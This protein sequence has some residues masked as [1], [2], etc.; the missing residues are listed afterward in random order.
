MDAEIG[1]DLPGREEVEIDWPGDD[2]TEATQA[3]FDAFTAIS[4]DLDTQSVLHRIV[5]T[6]CAL[7]AAPRG[8]LGVLGYDGQVIERIEHEAS[9]G[10]EGGPDVAAAMPAA[11]PDRPT[12]ALEVPVRVRGTPFGSLILSGRRDSTPFTKR[13]ELLVQALSTVAGFVIENARAYGL[14]ERRRR[15]L[16][17][18]GELTDLLMPPITLTEALERI[19]AAVRTASGAESSSVVQVPE[20]GTPFSA[21]SSGQVPALDAAEQ[22]TFDRAVRTVVDTGE[23]SSMT[24]SDDLVVVFAPL[25]AHLTIPG[26]LV[27]VR[28]R[29]NHSDEFEERELLLSFADQAALALDRTQALEDREA[30][31]VIS[32]RDRIARDL[33]DV[34]IQRL[35][36]AGLHM[37]SIKAAATPEL[38]ERIDQSVRDLDQTIRDIRGTIFEL[39]TRPQ[40]SLRS[41]IR[42]LVREY[43]PILGFAPSVQLDGPV[44]TSVD[45]RV[46]QQ[47]A[48]VL[49]ESLSNVARHAQAG[50]ASVEVRVTD[51]HLR[52]RVTDNGKG[53]PEER[54][55]SGLRNARRRAVMLGGHL[56]LWP[57]EPT[58]TAFIWSVPLDHP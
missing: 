16:E 47:F 1:P 21:A 17:M 7:T 20:D 57:Q 45:A 15:W 2:L 11:V 48:A 24:L 8:V 29:R 51:T 55:E 58:G 53:L 25:R 5:S 40:H 39:Q 41:E 38:K 4:S 14:S 22:T 46:Q 43:V 6:A 10:D 33:H 28:H 9:P 37:Q 23:V 42:D 27:V 36:A 31:A 26:V 50:N 30:M 32:D 56:D 12:L 35:F 44:D 54:R 19:A 3:L 13:D 52:L 49:R 18:F 34:V